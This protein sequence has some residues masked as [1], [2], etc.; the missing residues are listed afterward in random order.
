[1]AQHH[2]DAA[3][4]H[5]RASTA[6]ISALK[7]SSAAATR[8]IKEL[9]VRVDDL[10]QWT[11]VNV[12]FRLPAALCFTVPPTGVGGAMSPWFPVWGGLNLRF[13]WLSYAPDARG[14]NGL[15]PNQ[16]YGLAVDLTEENC[17]GVLM[18]GKLAVHATTPPYLSWVLAS[19]AVPAKFSSTERDG[20]YICSSM[21][22]TDSPANLQLRSQ[23]TRPDGTL[24]FMGRC[25]FRDP[26][27]SE[28]LGRDE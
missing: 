12:E 2:V 23:M 1:M 24:R 4:A 21:S 17:D 5:A 18:Y 15:D 20:S 11:V 13:R 9:E 10:S 7:E 19:R 6:E 16:C 28:F 3:D 26:V 22:L 27:A 25:M 14:I 8:R